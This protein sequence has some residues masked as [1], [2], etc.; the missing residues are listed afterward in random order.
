MRDYQREKNNPWH[1]P[2]HLYRQTLYLIRDYNRLKEDYTDTL[3][4]SHAQDGSGRSSKPGDPTGALACRLES[5]HDRIAAVEKAKQEIPEEYRQGV[6]QSIIYGTRYPDDAGRNTYS[7]WKA[8]F[9]WHVAK[10]M[11]WI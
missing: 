11:R 4:E 1:L 10:N 3:E 5:M 9:V 6:W 8:K 2:K 7:R